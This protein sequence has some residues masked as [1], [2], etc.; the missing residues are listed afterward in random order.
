MNDQAELERLIRAGFN[1]GGSPVHCARCGYGW[2]VYS[3]AA[4]DPA[5]PC[6]GCGRVGHVCALENGHAGDHQ[7]APA[8]TWWP[9]VD[10]WG[11]LA[12]G[13]DVIA[14]I[15]YPNGRIAEI[16]PIAFRRARLCLVNPTFR[17]SYDDVW[18]YEA[19]EL[20]LLWAQ[21]WDGAEDT[22]PSG[23]HRHP[24]TGRRRPGGDP[25][26]EEVRE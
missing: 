6:P 23:W 9:H 3:G 7:R 4:Y 25:E 10:A 2:S 17:E 15:W 21:V 26:L 14:R 5:L 11:E 8:P 20:A 22:E 18:C 12:D 13:H 16:A 19:P 24:A 1:F